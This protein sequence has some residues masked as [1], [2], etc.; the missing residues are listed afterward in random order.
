MSPDDVTRATFKTRG[1]TPVDVV[2]GDPLFC[3]LDN[4]RVRFERLVNCFEASGVP[5]DVM[6]EV[7]SNDDGR[8]L[9][10]LRHPTQVYAYGV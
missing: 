1:G 9:P 10:D 5:G 3:V 8:V 4:T 2:R 7:S 6:V